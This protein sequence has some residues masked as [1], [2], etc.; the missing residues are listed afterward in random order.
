MSVSRPVFV[1][2]IGT[3]VTIPG[4]A[5]CFCLNSGTQKEWMTSSARRL[6]LDLPAFGEAE[7][8]RLDAAVLRVLEVPGELLRGHVDLSRSDFS[9]PFSASATALTIAITVTSTVGIAV[10]AISMPV[11]PWIGGPSE[12]SS[13]R[14]RNLT[15]E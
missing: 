6:E 1:G 11:W 14:A 5:S 3:C 7:L 12:S 2:V 8:A 15:T 10:H 13:G 9:F 4:T